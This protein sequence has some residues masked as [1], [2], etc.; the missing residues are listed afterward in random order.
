M[1]SGPDLR[2]VTAR[3]V[4][5]GL[6]QVVRSV[7]VH[8]RVPGSFEAAVV[9]ARTLGWVDR[10]TETRID[11]T[12]PGRALLEADPTAVRRLAD[13]LTGGTVVVS[14]TNGKTTTASLVA[15]ILGA[16]GRRPV[17]NRVGANMPGGIAAELLMAARMPGRINGHTGVFE[18]DELWLEHVV[19]DLRPHVVALMNL[20]PDQLERTGGVDQVAHRWRRVV[21]RL[22]AGTHLLLGADD[23]VVVGLAE[24]A[25]AGVTVS[26]FSNRD[27]RRVVLHGL[28]GSA[29]E[30]QTPD[31]HHPPEV[32]LRLP[33]RFNVLNA[34]A[35]AA[36]ATALGV[37]QGAVVSG[38]EACDAPFGRFE[39]IEVD[40]VEVV[41]TL[42]KN[43]AALNEL[44]DFV[45][46]LEDVELL[47]LA[48]DGESGGRDLRWFAE[49]D[50]G[51]LAGLA[52]SVTVGGTRAQDAASAIGGDAKLVESIEGALDHAVAGAVVHERG[53]FVIATYWA[54]VEAREI[55]AERGHAARYWA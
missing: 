13:R 35:A 38:L 49:A 46:T 23:P 24:A 11:V 47:V 3:V 52:A 30:M 33:G 22:P 31:R 2:A 42:A 15:S 48:D 53:V 43:T 12:R 36:M 27:A 39:R 5:A 14:G 19:D 54:L 20:A 44:I 9:A 17:V 45:T 40:G 8:R 25:P 28:A 21:A 29:F 37:D 18:V 16:A 1:T 7:P 41:L 51:R 6:E 10:R 26:M 4:A 32:A 34:T 50:R 55:L